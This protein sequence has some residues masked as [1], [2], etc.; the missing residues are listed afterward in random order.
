MENK[1]KESEEGYRIISEL[2]SDFAFSLLVDEEGA[3]VVESFTD[4][5]TRI[6]GY[7]FDFIPGT[8]ATPPAADIS[9]GGAI[10]PS[11]SI[12]GIYTGTVNQTYTFRVVGDNLVGNGTLSLEVKDGAGADVGSFNIGA[13]YRAGDYIDIAD[14]I[15]IA[16][17]DGFVNESV[18]ADNFSIE[19]LA[20]SDTSGVLAATGINVFFSGSGASGMKHTAGLSSLGFGRGTLRSTLVHESPIDSR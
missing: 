12:A 7:S 18:T 4:A 16:L 19:A 5:F 13:G 1:L 2:V 11:V 3:Y 14:G 8:L 10:T 9:F 6:T 15:R 20:S 17:T